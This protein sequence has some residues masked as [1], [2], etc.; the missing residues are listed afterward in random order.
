MKIWIEVELHSNNLNQYSI[1]EREWL[2][3][4]VFK[5]LTP[6]IWIKMSEEYYNETIEYNFTPFNHNKELLLD[7]ANYLDWQ[8]K[9][10]NLELSNHRPAYVWMHIHIFDKSKLRISKSKLLLKLL[11]FL[12]ENLDWLDYNSKIRLIN[13]H[14][15]WTYWSHRNHHEWKNAI[16]N[17]WLD[18]YCYNDYSRKLKYA[19][20]ISS[21]ATRRG[22]PASLEIRLLPNE[23]LFNGKRLELLDEIQTKKIYE[24]EDMTFTEFAKAVY[25]N[26]NWI[27]NNNNNNN[28][29]NNRASVRVAY[30]EFLN[31][32]QVASYME[33][34]CEN[35]LMR[36]I[37][38]LSQIEKI[39]FERLL[40]ISDNYSWIFDLI[41]N[42]DYNNWISRLL[43]NIQISGIR[44]I[45]LRLSR[46][47]LNHTIIRD[48]L[49]IKNHFNILSYSENKLFINS[50]F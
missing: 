49:E 25:N 42:E 23:F 18:T 28:N 21:P 33:D 14:Q 26:I 2:R 13:A 19:P 1:C 10:Y 17:F 15:L 7:V 37:Y 35:L 30:N 36:D 39:E 22:K 34:T 41:K 38:S 29:N 31:E 24:R 27:R 46:I 9:K 8:I 12:A 5:D 50:R 40:Y 11:S 47:L 4:D 44:F 32:W 6:E 16:S 43:D 48:I 20:I 3:F 45:D